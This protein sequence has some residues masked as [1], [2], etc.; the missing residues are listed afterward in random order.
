MADLSSRTE[1]Q[2]ILAALADRLVF[3]VRNRPIPVREWHWADVPQVT[4][5]KVGAAFG[6]GPTPT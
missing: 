3:V 5:I 1:Q 2:T 4:V 6:S